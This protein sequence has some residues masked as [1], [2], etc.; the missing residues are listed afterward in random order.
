[1]PWSISAQVVG[2]GSG[3]A[4]SQKNERTP[5][6]FPFYENLKEKHLFGI[7]FGN[8]FYNKEGGITKE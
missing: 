4:I 6:G 1:M 2:K 3:T 8:Y 7:N 5:T